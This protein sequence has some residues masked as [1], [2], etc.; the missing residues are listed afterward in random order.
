[1][2]RYLDQLHDEFK[3]LDAGISTIVDRAADESRD[4]SDDEQKQIDRDQERAAD[5]EK[6]IKH[7]TEI[8]A[9]GERVN[10]MRDRVHTAPRQTKTGTEPE[11]EY[12]VEREFPTMGDYAVTLHRAL[13]LKDSAAIEKIERA[14]AHQKTTDNPG[15]IP[16]PIL[17]PV[18]NNLASVRPFIASITNRPLPAGKFDRPVIAQHVAV[19]VQAA[20]KDLTASQVLTVNALPVTAATYAGHLNISRQD[21]KWSSPA[22]LNIVFEDFAAVYAQVTDN[23]AADAF[24]ASVTDTT[25]VETLD[26]AGIYAAVYAAAAG[27]LGAVNQLPDTMWVAPD[28]WGALGGV[29]TGNG[30]PLF[31][32]LE[33]GSTA[34]NPMGLKLVVDGNFAP[35]TAIV[36]PSKLAE[37][38]E[39]ID[40]LMQVAEPDVLGQLVGYAGFGA[41]LNT[42]PAAFSKLVLP[43]VTP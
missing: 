6:S 22:I 29:M 20:E 11:P 14:T 21:I 19:G 9:R 27:T 34:G 1:M 18:I 25:D 42:T 23:A 17:G 43:V 10:V 24:V 31:A 40:G 41:F 2:G 28:V 33:P 30:G 38:F 32:Q 5:L 35:G 37:W 39:D 15:L 8:E 26:G 36:G 13:A 16:R 4:V 12:S 7:Y 3:E